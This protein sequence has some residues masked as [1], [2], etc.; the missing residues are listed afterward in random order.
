MSIQRGTPFPLGASFDGVGTNFSVFSSTADEVHLCLFDRRGHEIRLALPGKTAGYWH[1]YLHGVRPGQLYGFR[2]CGPYNP[3]SG[4]LF[5]PNKLLA[6]PY[7][8]ALSGKLRWHPSLLGRRRKD[9]GAAPEARDTARYVPRSVVADPFFDWEGDRPPRTP[10]CETLM[11]EAHV[12]GLT[13]SH[14]QVPSELRGTYAGLCEPALI[15][16]LRSLG[17]TTLALL[18]VHHFVTEQHLARKGLT[19][20]WGYNPLGYFA[21]HAAYAASELPG[22]QVPEFKAMV[23]H[24]HRAGLEVVL[25]VVFNHTAEGNER[26]P[27][28]SFKGL[29]NLV[30][31]RTKPDRPDLYEDF[32]GCGNAL[33]TRQPQVVRFIMDCLRYWVTEMHVDGFR[34]DL[35][36][37]L[38]RDE[39]DLNWSAPLLSAIG[40]DPTL[41]HVKLVAEPWDLG[42][43]GYCVG[44]FPYPWSEWNGQY[45]D[46]VRDYWRGQEGMLGALASRLTGSADIYGPSGR[47][48]CASVNFVTCHDGFTLRDLVSH[49]RRH[50]E[51]NGEDNRDGETHN[52]SWNCGV[53]GGTEDPRVNALRATQQR[54][55]LT[56]LLLSRGVPLLLAGDEMGRTQGGNN[57]AY[58]QDNRTT[59]L[60]WRHMDRGLLEFTKNLVRLRTQSTAFRRSGF[61]ADGQ[62]PVSYGRAGPG[63][64]GCA[65]NT[66]VRATDGCEIAWFRPDG[67]AMSERDWEVPFARALTVLFEEPATAGGAR[68]T[69]LLMFNA[70]SEALTFALPDEPPGTSGWICVLDT[71]SVDSTSE[72]PCTGRAIELPPRSTRVLRRATDCDGYPMTP[73]RSNARNSLKPPRRQPA[74]GR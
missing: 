3:G 58:C 35:A 55:L 43:D 22:S 37:A 14:P 33:D 64:Y 41:R 30:Y 25:D 49:N 4:L 45:R 2:A 34:F 40:Q 63:H 21:P 61:C 72:I 53:E 15:D 42:P 20:F 19:N 71:S 38:I 6:D 29:D 47:S 67:K 52:R 54:N 59:W 10:W 56:T 13:A 9:R 28:L 16:H 18:P 7:A 73:P 1:G 5:N 57:N 66:Q 31:Y 46:V 68:G 44:G 60:D 24:L 48:A 27:V 39:R 11:Y 8:R 50:N 32:S 26:G 51:P 17:V 23:K 70:G 12:R 69:Y 74:I 65:Q 36:A 62:E